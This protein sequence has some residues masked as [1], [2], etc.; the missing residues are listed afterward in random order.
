[1]SI[2]EIIL[3]IL[4]LLLGSG[5]I[6]ALFT[7][8]NI[9]KKA[10]GESRSIIANAEKD[11]LD[12]EFYKHEIEKNTKYLKYESDLKCQEHNEQLM[13]ILQEKNKLQIIMS[14]DLQNIRIEQIKIREE[15][16]LKI[17]NINK[18]LLLTIKNLNEVKS[19]NENMHQE[20]ITLKN[21]ICI[22]ENC[23]NKITNL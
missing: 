8:R 4:T 2:L 10:E 11:E 3:S 20:I 17:N 13:A 18:E 7:I 12:V 16:E 5:G 21:L 23:E 14:E 9:K 15:Y 19:E 6:A 22:R 1:M